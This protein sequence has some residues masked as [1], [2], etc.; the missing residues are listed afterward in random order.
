M[1]GVIEK[2]KSVF[3]IGLML[4]MFL[5]SVV[6]AQ[7]Y[8]G[9]FGTNLDLRRG[10]ENIIDGTVDIMEPFL[11]VVLGGEDYTGLLLFE[12][13]LLFMI[14]LS[15][16][17][18]AIS[19]VPAF[20]DNKA[21]VWIISIVIP[22][23]SIRYMNFIWINT[24]LIQYQVLGIAITAFLPFLIYMFFLHNMTESTI[25]RKMGWILFIVIYFGLW[26]TSPEQNYGIVYFWTMIVAFLMLWLDG[27]LHRQYLK[28]ILK[29][30][31]NLKKWEYIRLLRS[32]IA[33]TEQSVNAGHIPTKV[34]DKIIKQKKKLVAKYLKMN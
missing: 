27:T 2:K 20:E 11:Q 16:V 26:A 31:G 17:Y 33:L 23:L 4:S 8:G 24:I 18:F 6:S 28:Y 5:I 25:V 9:S 3:I 12:R 14:I 13:F 19:R 32:E 34:G 22:I 30:K 10:S 7:S 1:K 21:V 15:I 29:E